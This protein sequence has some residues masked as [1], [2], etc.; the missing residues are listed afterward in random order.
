MLV[1][2]YTTFRVYL[3]EYSKHTNKCSGFGGEILLN[4]NHANGIHARKSTKAF[5]STMK[6][7][8]NQTPKKFDIITY[9]RK[10]L[11]EDRLPEEL[12]LLHYTKSN[13]M[14]ICYEI[15]ESIG[16]NARVAISYFTNS[17][18]WELLAAS[19]NIDPEVKMFLH[20]QFSIEADEKNG[21]IPYK[22]SFHYYQDYNDA[23]GWEPYKPILPYMQSFWEIPLHNNGRAL[24]TLFCY[25]P[26][27]NKCA[28]ED[29]IK[30]KPYLE[31]IKREIL[32]YE[33][34]LA[35]IDKK[36]KKLN[37]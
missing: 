29:R 17:K 2:N 21:M 24:G 27:K 35:A 3:V 34:V 1:E 13:L 5:I 7:C 12:Y 22:N 36:K 19:P 33:K 11:L 10:L 26:E 20:K 18:Y 9:Y 37:H 28:F 6:E 15:A 31:D 4:T 30:S 32:D 23:V 8:Y 16:K 25:Y 14:S